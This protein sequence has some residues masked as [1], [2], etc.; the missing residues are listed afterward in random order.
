MVQ[1]NYCLFSQKWKYKTNPSAQNNAKPQSNRALRKLIQIVNF[2]SARAIFPTFDSHVLTASKPAQAA[3]LPQPPL[4]LLLA[5]FQASPEVQE[6]Q[7]ELSVN[8]SSAFPISILSS[9]L[10]DIKTAQTNHTSAMPRMSELGL[11]EAFWQ[12]WGLLTPTERPFQAAAA[13]CASIKNTS[14]GNRKVLRRGWKQDTTRT[15]PPALCL[16][17]KECSGRSDRQAEAAIGSSLLP[18]MH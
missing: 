17:L 12:D 5:T 7:V 13:S 9:P 18:E 8:S 16:C 15:I 6:V 1:Q 3:P 14:G 11:S 4:A 2:F 10:G